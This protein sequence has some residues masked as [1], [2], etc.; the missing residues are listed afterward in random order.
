MDNDVYVGGK[1]RFKIPKRTKA[2]KEVEEC[3]EEPLQETLKR[4]LFDKKLS[5]SKAGYEMGVYGATVYRWAKRFGYRPKRKVY[6]ECVKGKNHGR[7]VDL[8]NRFMDKF[9]VE[10]T[11]YNVKR[12]AVELGSQRR[13][14]ERLGIRESTICECVRKKGIWASYKDEPTFR[15]NWRHRLRY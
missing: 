6:Y 2:I 3:L 4:L 8:K 7:H 11:P 1:V 14:A 12:K 5:Y 15:Q 10:M 9:D 13:L